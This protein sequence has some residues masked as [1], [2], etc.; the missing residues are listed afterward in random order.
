AENSTQGTAKELRRMGSVTVCVVPVQFAPF[1][2]IPC[3]AAIHAQTG[4]CFFDL[5]LLLSIDVDEAEP[6]TK[7]VRVL[8]DPIDG[9]R[10]QNQ[11]HGQRDPLPDFQ[12]FG[13]DGGHADGADLNHHAGQGGASGRR[14]T[15]HVEE[16][17]QGETKMIVWLTWT[18]ESGFVMSSRLSCG[19]L[20]VRFAHLS[21]VSRRTGP[22]K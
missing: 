10:F 8:H 21:I 3:V 18:G 6:V 20:L 15:A 1:D 22:S 16:R 2:T 9:E 4:A 7:V 11:L 13:N 14:R 19:W 5:P 12:I 17:I